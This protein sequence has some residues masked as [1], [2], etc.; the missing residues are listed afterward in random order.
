M[1]SCLRRIPNFFQ[2]GAPNFDIVFKR[3]FSG[4]II[5]RLIEKM[6]GSMGVRGHTRPE[7]LH[8]VMAIL[9]LFEQFL[10]K[11]CLNF[12]PLNLS[13]HQI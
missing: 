12:L 6:K 10:G 11:F 9:V 7:N 8:T 13:V 2:R 3:I 5:V 4:R 1:F